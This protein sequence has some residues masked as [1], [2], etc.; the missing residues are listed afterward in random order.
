MKKL[1]IILFFIP[2]VLYCQSWTYNDGS[3]RFDGNFKTSYAKVNGGLFP[4]NEPSLILINYEKGGLRFYLNNTGFYQY[5]T[6]LSIEFLFDES[7]KI[8]EINDYSLSNDGSAIF[9][10]SMVSYDE[11]FRIDGTYNLTQMLDLFTKRNKAFIRVSNNFKTIDLKVSLTGST[12]AINYVYPELKNDLNDLKNSK[13]KKEL[14]LEKAI[15]RNKLIIEKYNSV[16]SD[17]SVNKLKDIL[18]DKEKVSVYK[19]LSTDTVSDSIY[20]KPMNFS[21]RNTENREVVMYFV[22]ENNDKEPITRVDL[23]EE[24]FTSIIFTPEELK[25]KNEL[26]KLN[27]SEDNVY[28][29]ISFF[30]SKK[31][32]IESI[33]LS[34]DGVTNSEYNLGFIKIAAI[35]DNGSSI[36]M[37]KLFKR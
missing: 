30:R 19:L 6:K 14:T 21:L 10:N 12:K 11:S 23:S 37:P 24:F 22:S 32:K 18:L 1:L 4:Y 35:L 26:S 36:V 5:D 3:N 28:E 17:N 27:I 2:T 31:V 34:K 7:N 13:L 16:M 25:A 15:E 33:Y 9:L 8:F 29:I 20:F